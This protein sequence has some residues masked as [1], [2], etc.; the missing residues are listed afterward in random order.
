MEERTTSRLG[1]VLK[2][3]ATWIM[4]S[5]IRALVHSGLR[6]TWGG[7]AEQRASHTGSRRRDVYKWQE[8]DLS[9]RNDEDHQQGAVFGHR[10]D[11]KKR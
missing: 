11:L 10:R 2:L 7:Y 1:S 9:R 5:F 6:C 8:F 3:E 4:T